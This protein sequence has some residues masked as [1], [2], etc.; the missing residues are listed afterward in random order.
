M[1]L[2]WH[3]RRFAPEQQDVVAPIAVVEIGEGAAGGEKHE[4]MA[5]ASLLRFEVPPRSVPDDR[6]GIEI[7]HPGAAEGA[8]GGGKAGRPDEVRFDADAAHS[9]R[10]VPVFCGMS[11]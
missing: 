3:A 4:A 1:H 10:I 7:V 2:G 11:G 5:V 8:V 6:D 9:R